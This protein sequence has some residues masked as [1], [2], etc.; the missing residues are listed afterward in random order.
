MSTDF[1]LP[2]QEACWAYVSCIY[3]MVVPGW[4]ILI[5]LW[6]QFFSLCKM[7]ID[8]SQHLF[9]KKVMC[10]RVFG[11]CLDICQKPNDLQQWTNAHNKDT[12]LDYQL[13]ISTSGRWLERR[14]KAVFS[15]GNY[16]KGFIIL[17]KASTQHIRPPP[18]HSTGTSLSRCSS[19]SKLVMQTLGYCVWATEAPLCQWDGRNWLTCIC[20]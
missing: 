10:Q 5:T 18:S 7:A 20:F 12:W 16:Q 11:N 1:N 4:L 8:Q 15:L 19:K 9:S 14:E 3:I 13:T 6:L 2:H 17:I